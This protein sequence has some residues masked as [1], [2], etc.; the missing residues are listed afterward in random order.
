MSNISNHFKPPD[1]MF[2]SF[3]HNHAFDRQR[4]RRTDGQKG[5]D[6]NV[7]CISCSRTV[8]MISLHCTIPMEFLS[9]ITSPHCFLQ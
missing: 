7:R 8:K 2:L 3:C 1:D 5:L 6:N 4:D 9:N